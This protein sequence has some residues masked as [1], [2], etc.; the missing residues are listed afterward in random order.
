MKFRRCEEPEL[1]HAIDCINSLAY[2]ICRHLRDARKAAHQNVSS[3]WTGVSNAE[4]SS[5]RL[6]GNADV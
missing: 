1:A 5:I 2:T 4:T 3:K 6:S